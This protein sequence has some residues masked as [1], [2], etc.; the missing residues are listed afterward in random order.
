MRYLLDEHLSAAS[1][2]ICRLRFQ[3]DAV[4]VEELGRK[5]RTDEEQLD[6][7]AAEGR[8]IVTRDREDFTELTFAFAED[9]RPHAG[10]LLV[11]ESIGQGDHFGIAASI[12]RY[13]REHPDGMPAYMVDYV[14]GGRG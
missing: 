10:V 6:Y 7:A 14:R 9:A 13:E 1:A 8:V 11:P 5:G 2:R 4:C 3:L 12:A